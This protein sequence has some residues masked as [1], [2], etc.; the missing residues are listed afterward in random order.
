MKI[1]KINDMKNG[2]IVGKFSPS[3]YNADYEIGIKKYKTNDEELTHHHR[4]ATEFTIVI[5]GVISM[6]NILFSE[7]DII[8]VDTFEDVKFKCIKDAVTVVFKTISDTNDK[9]ITEG[10]NL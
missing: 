1:F 3:V 4:L 8:Q 7:G 9:Y 2:W 5:S 10:N 6:N